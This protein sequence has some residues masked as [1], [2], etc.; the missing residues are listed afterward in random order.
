MN[1]KHFLN[2]AVPLFA[3]FSAFG[4][5]KP[6]TNDWLH[7][8]LPSAIPPYLAKGDLIGI[9]CPAG[10]ITIE[11]I[12]PA[13]NRLQE[14]GYNIKLGSTIGKRDFTFGGTDEERLAES[15][16]ADA[17]TMILPSPLA[18]RVSEPAA[19]PPEGVRK[20]QDTL[21]ELQACRRLLDVAIAEASV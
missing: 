4:K 19:L 15:R 9:T 14:W 16:R 18:P 21:N 12:Q 11:E 8:D 3:G 5:N 13:F 2:F 20:L 7:T 10:F 17:D 6:G 1:R